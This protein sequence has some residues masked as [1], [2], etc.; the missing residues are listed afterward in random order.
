MDGTDG[1]YRRRERAT[2][3]PGMGTTAT[4]QRRRRTEGGVGRGALRGLA[5]RLESAGLGASQDLSKIKA[6]R[7]PKKT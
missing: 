4:P 6:F 5:Q 2:D 7:T 1:S 3:A